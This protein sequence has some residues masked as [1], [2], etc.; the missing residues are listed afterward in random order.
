MNA[1]TNALT[2]SVVNEF[3]H[4]LIKEQPLAW[5]DRGNTAG[6]G[7]LRHAALLLPPDCQFE[8]ETQKAQNVEGP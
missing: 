1:S 7:V 8:T 5:F 2:L 4:A 6:E 3:M